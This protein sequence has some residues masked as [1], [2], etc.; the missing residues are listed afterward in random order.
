MTDATRS[1]L[2]LKL[3][4]AATDAD[5]AL[6]DVAAMRQM[7]A[8]LELNHV[9][10]L[11][12]VLEFTL[13]LRFDLSILF[14]DYVENEH[15]PQAHV[16]ARFL[17]L[18]IY[19][20]A[21]TYRHLLGKQ[22][23][24]ELA[25]SDDAKELIPHIRRVHKALNTIASE[26]EKVYGDVRNGIA[27]HRDADAIIQLRR[28]RDIGGEELADFVLRFLQAAGELEVLLAA[29]TAGIAQSVKNHVRVVNLR[30]GAQ[31]NINVTVSG[32]IPVKS[33]QINVEEIDWD[34]SDPTVAEV[35]TFGRVT[36]HSAGH[37]RITFR[38]SVAPEVDGGIF[39]FVGDDDQLSEMSRAW[40]AL[41]TGAE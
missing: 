33:R 34:S 26:A 35:D 38:S 16:Y 17:I 32:S 30:P 12:R 24:A 3:S 9:A 2:L 21:K 1:A 8:R 19:E 14:A 23:Q 39:V 4:E 18:T 31:A 37:S 5:N 29:V 36:A 22:L 11:F 41:I 10:E 13:L 20:G 40:N 27:A 6:P 7:F 28:L 15:R 25:S